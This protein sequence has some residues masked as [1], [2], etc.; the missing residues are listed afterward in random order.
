MAI[1][2]ASDGH[3]VEAAIRQQRPVA[4]KIMFGAG[5]QA[6]LFSGIDA[7]RAAAEIG[8]TAKANL[9]KCN[10][11]C[12]AHHQIDFAV[13]ATII[14]SYQAQ[15]LIEQMLTGEAF[16]PGAPGNRAWARPAH[17]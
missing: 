6:R 11:G 10:G 7:F 2:A 4:L 5:Q 14:S 8:S 17:R 13:P 12:V 16:G 1:A 9:D 15:T 3:D